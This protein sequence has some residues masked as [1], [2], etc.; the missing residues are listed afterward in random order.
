MVACLLNQSKTPFTYHEK[1]NHK[2]LD[3]KHTHKCRYDLYDKK[4]EILA[5]TSENTEATTMA[6]AEEKNISP[7]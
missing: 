5:R 3:K 2:K 4:Q 7:F 1:H 6:G